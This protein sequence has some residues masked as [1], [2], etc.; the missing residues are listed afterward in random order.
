MLFK[1][2]EYILQPEEINFP[3]GKIIKYLH[4]ALSKLHNFSPAGA[5]KSGEPP[6]APCVHE[7]HAIFGEPDI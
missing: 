6:S 7:L 3:L 1:K 2:E 4:A 5:Y